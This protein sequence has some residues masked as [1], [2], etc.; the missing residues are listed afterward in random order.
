M[1]AYRSALNESLAPVDTGE[2]QPVN[3]GPIQLEVPVVLAPMAGVTDWPFRS[4]CSHF[5]A[6]LY[7]NQMI[8]ARALVEENA[9]T[10]KLAEFGVDEPIRSIQLY[11]TDP[12]YVSLA[13][14]MLK[15]RIG[16]DHIDMNFGCPAPKV[17]KNGGGAAIPV[18]RRLLASIVESAVEAAGNIPVTIK[19]RK[20]I[21]DEHLTFLDSGRIAQESGCVG[22]TLHARTA[23]DLY[24][25]HADWDAIGELVNHIDIPVFGNGDIWESWD[26]VRMIRYT[27]AAGVEIGRGCRGRP[28]LCSELVAGLSGREPQLVQPSLGL[29]ADVMLDHVAR[30]LD[31]YDHDENDI[32]RR[33]RKHAGWYVAGWPVGR[34][35]RRRL[36]SANRLDELKSITDEFDRGTLLPPE[37]VRVKRSHTGGPRNVS[38]PENWLADP[39]EVVAL[40]SAAE[41]NVSGG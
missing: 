4:L 17:T 6:A 37:G 30:L 28:W 11:G 33:F 18:K 9:L 35:L 29:V 41:A 24:S 38:L 39:D 19:F 23:R 7:V 16:V 22:V 27:G 34:D 1:T 36:H 8:T 31:F 40:S 25:G 15:D 2:I 10:W 26:A 32:V 14:H 13:V 20:G 3:L 5:G 12:K 21:D